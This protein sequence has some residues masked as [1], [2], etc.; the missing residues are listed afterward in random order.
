MSAE[1]IRKSRNSGN[2]GSSRIS[3]TIR[4]ATEA[5]LDQALALYHEFHEFHVRGVPD[6][7]R[8]PHPYGDTAAH[9]TL[10]KVL[11]G[12]DAALFVAEERGRLIGL[13]EAYLRRDTPHPAAIEYVY[14][15]LQSL[16]VTAA[17][18]RRGLGRRLVA[19]AEEWS[20]ERGASE[21]RLSCWEFAEGPLPFYEALGYRTMKRTLVRSL[22]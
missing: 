3:V 15:Y 2:S 18:R 22:E 16:I 4:R 20:R 19:A 13:A 8:V 7:L 17:I 14:G 6:R 12:E 11:H 5:D 9:E 21:M 10:V 1:S